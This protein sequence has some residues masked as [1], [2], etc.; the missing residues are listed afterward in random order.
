[1]SVGVSDEVI[2][3]GDYHSVLGLIIFPKLV[4]IFL[5]SKIISHSSTGRLDHRMWYQ[6][7]LL[8]VE[9]GDTPAK[10]VAIA[11]WQREI[12]LCGDLQDLKKL[13]VTSL[14]ARLWFDNLWDASE[15]D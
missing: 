1:V 4:L 13:T 12:T 8:C 5:I 10:T 14:L 3:V 6:Y 7:T 15:I 11:F 9:M 2:V